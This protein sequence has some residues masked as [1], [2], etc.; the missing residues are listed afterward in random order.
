M[1]TKRFWKLSFA[2]FTI[3]FVLVLFTLAI[4][5]Q[6]IDEWTASITVKNVDQIPQTAN[7]TFGINPN[8]TTGIDGDFD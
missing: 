1:T 6:S 3:I 5:A 4:Q 7:V 8:S 2:S